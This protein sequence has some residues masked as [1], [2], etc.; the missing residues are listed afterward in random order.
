M[1]PNDFVN[2]N[3]RGVELPWGCKDLIDVLKLGGSEQTRGVEQQEGFSAS[4][5]QPVISYGA[6]SDIE[7]RIETFLQW[8]TGELLFGVGVQKGGILVT[9]LKRTEGLTLNSCVPGKQELVK[10]LIARIFENAKFSENVWGVEYVSVALSSGTDAVA[11]KMVELLVGG[12]GVLEGE[13]LMFVSYKAVG[14]GEG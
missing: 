14:T 9:L 3:Q 5:H 2:P 12:F 6:L 1:G 4:V 13:Q 10:D 7:Q 8:G 11:R